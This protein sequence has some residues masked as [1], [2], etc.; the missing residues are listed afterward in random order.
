MFNLPSLRIGRILGIPVEVN[1]TWLVVFALVA[2][3]LAFSYFPAI[4]AWPSWLYV[5]N[6]A[7]T[8]V[9]FF[10]SIVIHEMSHSL[11]ARAGGIR[12]QK[13]TLFLFGGVAQMEEE[14]H[15]PGREFVMALAGPG[16]SL[17][18]AALFWFA[19]L[20]AAA[21]GAPDAVWGPLEYLAFINLAVAIFNLLPGF[22]LDGGRVLRAA[23]WGLTGDQ[24]KATR[25]AARA[26]QAVGYILIALA[27][28]GVLNGQLNLIW[29][30]LVGW[31]IVVLAENAYRQ[32]L[33]RSRL[34][35]LRVSEIMSS[36]PVMVPGEITLEELAH[37][38]MLGERHSRYPVVE[39]GTVVGL[40]SL[41]GVKTVNRAE[42]PFVTVGDIADRDLPS[43]LVQGTASVESVLE[44]LAEDVPGALLVLQEGLVTGIATRADVMP[45]VGRM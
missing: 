19:W 15:G 28:F 45:H 8:A 11:V 18:L 42:W 13:I 40:V 9:L 7:I 10:A 32:Q 38:Y 20:G 24:L 35:D 12:I 31:F 5:V 44:R 22:P 3:S 16:A 29:L 25:W 34:G 26:G 14:P 43:M 23:L 30:G 2:F 33:M 21:L 4:Y 17:G 1:L 6:G 37:D 27:V 36:Q 41:A 39:N